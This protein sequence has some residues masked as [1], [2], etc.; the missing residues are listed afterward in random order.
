MLAPMVAVGFIA[1]LGVKGYSLRRD[2][3][4]APQVETPKK[5]SDPENPQISTT[6]SEEEKA[7]STA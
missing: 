3:K 4:Q 7:A 2:V 1:V 5:V 6:V